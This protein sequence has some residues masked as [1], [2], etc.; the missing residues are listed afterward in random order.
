MA[1]SPAR[2]DCAALRRWVKVICWCGHRGEGGNKQIMAQ[3]LGIC[4]HMADI[5]YNLSFFIVWFPL[6]T[7]LSCGKKQ[8]Q[9]NTPHLPT[10]SGFDRCCRANRN[11]VKAASALATGKVPGGITWFIGEIYQ[12]EEEAVRWM[13]E[14]ARESR[15]TGGWKCEKQNS[16]TS[17]FPAEVQNIKVWLCGFLVRQWAQQ[18]EISWT[19]HS[20]EKHHNS[21]STWLWIISP[22]NRHA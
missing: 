11:K 3:R 21:G 15:L 20:R 18:T 1:M 7:H 19:T 16:D 22:P 12:K 5:P 17:P 13:N 10:C 6:V 8:N 4:R 2:R 9:S 14:T